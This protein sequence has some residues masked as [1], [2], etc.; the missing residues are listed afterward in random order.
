MG[1]VSVGPAFFQYLNGNGTDEDVSWLAGQQAMNLICFGQLVSSG[2]PC[3]SLRLECGWHTTPDV[4]RLDFKLF[5]PLAA[6]LIQFEFADSNTRPVLKV[7]CLLKLPGIFTNLQHLTL[8]MHTVEGLAELI[9][10]GQKLRVDINLHH[11][12]FEMPVSLAALQ[13]SL[14]VSL[15]T[16]RESPH[17]NFNAVIRDVQRCKEWEGV[18]EGLVDAQPVCTNSK[19]LVRKFPPKHDNPFL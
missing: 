1:G 7:G 12:D 15:T 17:F 18:W 4:T 8:T 11:L 6:G 2:I 5:Q 14:E 13:H 16:T 19:L 10:V 9:A 3:G